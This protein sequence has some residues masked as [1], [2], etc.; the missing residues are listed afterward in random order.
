MKVLLVVGAVMVALL[1]GALTGGVLTATGQE[2]P[3][4]TGVAQVASPDKDEPA[5][6]RA[7]GNPAARAFVAAKKEWTVCVTEAAPA[8][9]QACGT[10]PHPHDF[11]GKHGEKHGPPAWAG[12]PERRTAEP[13]G[14]AER[15]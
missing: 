4:R 12:G 1:A 3:A 5:E 9:E 13:P 8:R 10:K 2:P 11:A 6:E 14:H 7:E 15:D